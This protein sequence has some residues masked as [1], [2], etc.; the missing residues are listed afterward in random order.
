MGKA[1]RIRKIKQATGL[2][3]I[4]SRVS[5]YRV[6]GVVDTMADAKAASGPSTDPGQFIENSTNF[7]RKDKARL[8]LRVAQIHT[9]KTYE[10]DS[11][12]TAQHQIDWTMPDNVQIKADGTVH[13]DSRGTLQFIKRAEVTYKNRLHTNIRVIGNTPLSALTPMQTNAK[14]V[15]TLAWDHDFVLKPGARRRV[16]IKTFADDDNLYRPLV[17]QLDIGTDDATLALTVLNCTAVLPDV[18][19][20]SGIAVNEDLSALDIEVVVYYTVVQ[21]NSVKPTQTV[22]EYVRPTFA[23]KNLPNLWTM[24]WIDPQFLPVTAPKPPVFSVRDPDTPSYTTIEKASVDFITFTFV[25]AGGRWRLRLDHCEANGSS[26]G[27]VALDAIANGE[28]RVVLGNLAVPYT[29]SDMGCVPTMNTCVYHRSTRAWYL[30]DPKSDDGIWSCGG[31]Y[32]LKQSMIPVAD[33]E[34]KHQYFSIGRLS[35][36]DEETQS[37]VSKRMGPNVRAGYVGTVEKWITGFSELISL[38]EHAA[39]VVGLFL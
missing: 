13:R 9:S 1:N 32:P 30:S 7:N 4:G 28:H 16:K 2:P 36:R 10:A 39:A 23:F 3:P 33:R 31:D 26:K 15:A 27:Q 25:A 20:Y 12:T 24:F 6:D 5:G 34:C 37:E 8:G 38:A 14:T 11:K 35:P 19:E 17:G 29:W 22:Q 21:Q 18:S